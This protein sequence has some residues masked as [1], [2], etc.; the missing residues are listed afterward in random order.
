MLDKDLKEI[1]NGVTDTN[2]LATFDALAIAGAQYFLCESTLQPIALSDPFSGGSLSARAPPPLRAY[3]LTDRPLYRPG[4]S[5]QFKGFVREEQGGALKIP[6]ARKVKWTIERVYANEVLASGET[7]VD[8][9]G[10][11]NGTWTPP[12]GFGGWRFRR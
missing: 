10:G 2:G 12:P 3:T 11:W 4:Q 8:A 5:V 7:K 1:A 6:A 9:E